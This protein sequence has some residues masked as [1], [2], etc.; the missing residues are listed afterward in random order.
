MALSDWAAKLPNI[1]I[2]SQESRLGKLVLSVL[3]DMQKLFGCCIIVIH[4]NIIVM[5]TS[6][7][8]VRS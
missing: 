5:I 2:L 8:L 1:P 3:N 4:N 7:S 6:I